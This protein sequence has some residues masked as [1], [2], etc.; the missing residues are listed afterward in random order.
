MSWVRPDQE[1]F[2][3]LLHTPSN[4]QLNNADMLVVSQKLGRKQSHF[5]NVFNEI[6]NGHTIWN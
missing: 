3:D 6:G 4:A 5:D 1:I 2:P